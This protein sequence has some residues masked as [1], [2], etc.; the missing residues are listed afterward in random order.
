MDC[1]ARVPTTFEEYLYEIYLSYK[2]SVEPEDHVPEKGKNPKPCLCSKCRNSWLFFRI[3]SFEFKNNTP[4][5]IP[6]GAWA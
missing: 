6:S 2:S 3:W 1:A 5:N 4:K